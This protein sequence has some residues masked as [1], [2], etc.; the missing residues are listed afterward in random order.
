[1]K[2]KDL[3]KGKNKMGGK[4]RWYPKENELIY[5]KTSIF[6][7]N[8]LYCI[9][10]QYNPHRYEVWKKNADNSFD[11]RKSP[12]FLALHGETSPYIRLQIGYGRSKEKAYEKLKRFFCLM[13]DIKLRGMD[14][15]PIALVR[16]IVKNLYNCGLE[17]YEGHHRCAIAMFLKMTIPVKIYEIKGWGHEV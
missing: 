13:Q 7:Y 10:A 11:M 5:K 12:H 14:S 3:E 16:P 15:P 17:W 8:K 4:L 1:M 9:K 2:I 6:Q